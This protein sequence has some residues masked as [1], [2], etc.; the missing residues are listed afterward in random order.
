MRGE[1]SDLFRDSSFKLY[2]GSIEA[3]KQVKDEGLKTAN[4]TS[5]PKPFF[6]NGIKPILDYLDFICTGYEAGYEKSNPQI[7]QIILDRLNIKPDETVVIGDNPV[8][9]ISNAK[10]LGLATIQLL[11]QEPP[12]EMADETAHNVLEAVK[13][14]DKLV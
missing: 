2:P 4:A 12:S 9:D 7:F 13:I 1:L 6:I 11:S 8:L 5:T 10:Q 3:L 14:L